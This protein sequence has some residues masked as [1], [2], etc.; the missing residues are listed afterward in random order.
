MIVAHRGESHEAPE[1]TLPAFELAWEQG[2][3][4]I[5]ADF[6]LTQDG[7]IV[8]IHDRNTKRVSDTHVV[9]RNAT[10]AELRKLDVGGHFGATFEGTTMPTMAEVLSTVP[11]QKRIYIE[12]KCGT[13]I[14]SPLLEQIEKAGL[15]SEQIVVIC[16]KAKVLQELKAKAPQYNVSWLCNFHENEAGDMTPSL[17]TVLETLALIQANGLSSNS[18][19][20]ESFI[21]AIE[22]KGYAWHVWTIDDLETA[23]RMHALGAKSITSNRAGF[24]RKNLL[25]QGAEGG[26]GTH[27]R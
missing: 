6:H 17:E 4:A 14:I 23:Q 7:H 18:A 3:D 25:E 10:L 12:V 20:P 22:Q 27:A 19:I 11:D 2:V 5:E 15:K 13:E 9:V 26:A 21:E 16:F 1:N 8:C 24:I